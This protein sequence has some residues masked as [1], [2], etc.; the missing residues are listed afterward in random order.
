MT[1]IAVLGAGSWGTALANTMA[2]NGQ[3]VMIWSHKADQ[4]AEINERHQNDRY[5]PGAKLED[6]LQATDQMAAAVSG[7]DI[8]LFVVPTKA[9]R[10]VAKQL[11]A[12]LLANKQSVILAHATK[13]LEQKTHLRISQMLVEEIPADCYSGLA[14]I[15]GPSHAEDVVKGDLTAISIGSNDVRAAEALQ[16]ALANAHFRPYTNHDLIGSELG[17]ALKNIIAIGSGMLIGKGYG[18]NAQA[19]LLTR[20]LVEIRE[21]GQALGAQPE[22]FLGLAG[23]GDLIVTGMSP[24][25]RNY[26]AGV[27]LAS[28]KPL[29]QVEE[30][31]GMVIEG[32]NTIK[33]VVDFEKEYDLDLPITRTLYQ[34]IYEGKTIDQGIN[35]SMTRP[36]KAED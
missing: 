16:G 25:S 29:A 19:A 7:A 17:G 10:Q 24:N 23:I 28:G 34:V 13:G 35:D 6:N 27:A 20:G 2:K 31:M 8:V 9:I 14:V 32:V 1:K 22:T 15:S 30:E 5:L 33:A 12:I 4:A 36:L 11:A 26:R 18:A 3:Q 21:V